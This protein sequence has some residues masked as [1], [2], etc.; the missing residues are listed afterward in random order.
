MIP[1]GS[2]F[3][4]TQVEMLA[5]SANNMMVTGVPTEKSIHED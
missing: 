3:E 2:G 5:D 1:R 4:N